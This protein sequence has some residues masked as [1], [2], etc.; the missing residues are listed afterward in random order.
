[1]VDK[2]NGLGEGGVVHVKKKPVHSFRKE[3]ELCEVKKKLKDSLAET[4]SAQLRELLPLTRE[5][6]ESVRSVLGTPEGLTR[7]LM[8][9]DEAEILS[10]LRAHNSNERDTPVELACDLSTQYLRAFD[11]LFKCRLDVENTIFKSKGEE[12]TEV[13]EATKLRDTTYVEYLTESKNLSDACSTESSLI[14]RVQERNE[15]TKACVD[16]LYQLLDESVVVITAQ[17]PS[18][19]TRSV[20]ETLSLHDDWVP[21]KFAEEKELRA[22]VKESM[23]NLALSLKTYSEV[24][25]HCDDP[26]KAIAHRKEMDIPEE[27]TPLKVVLR[28]H[29]ATKE[30]W[31]T[32]IARDY[33]SKVSPALI[34]STL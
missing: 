25:L 17:D 32:G 10:V 20:V 8:R 5:A 7:V 24:L 9:D 26:P 6:V 31:L 2:Q 27:T 23:T 33:Q 14:G 13:L 34:C 4:E 1:V 12:T 21:S 16:G 11:D 18:T 28:E 29:I 15:A 3:T 22:Q 30:T 19:V